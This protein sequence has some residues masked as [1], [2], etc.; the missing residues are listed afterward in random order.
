VIAVAAQEIIE[1]GV[2]TAK[3]AAVI[4]HVKNNRTEYLVL[5]VFTHMLGLT[6]VLL[7]QASGVC[8]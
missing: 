2:K 8:G 1:T 5:L 7:Q 6:D 3:T 4:N